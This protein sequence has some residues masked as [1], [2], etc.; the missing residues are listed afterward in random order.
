MACVHLSFKIHQRHQILSFHT[1]KTITSEDVTVSEL[2]AAESHL[3][4]ALGWQVHPPI[5]EMISELY[6]RILRECFPAADYNKI[7]EKCIFCLD[8]ALLDDFYLGY[9]P[10]VL[11]MAA[12]CF[13]IEPF[14]KQQEE[15]AGYEI[16]PNPIQEIYRVAGIL[17]PFEYYMDCR[18]RM[19]QSMKAS[20]WFQDIPQFSSSSS[21]KL[22]SSPRMTSPVSIMHHNHH[23]H[24]YYQYHH[25]HHHS[26]GPRLVAPKPRRRNTSSSSSSSWNPPRRL[27]HGE[28]KQLD[29]FFRPAGPI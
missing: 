2:E 1:L 28:P 5:P 16:Y 14:C 6:F 15:Y 20:C 4:E 11:T 29:K 22:H 24:Q 7:H 17:I 23:N 8:Q 25:H 3:V 19:Y 26:S 10:T 9:A 27:H 13:T 18:K 21:Q 12:F